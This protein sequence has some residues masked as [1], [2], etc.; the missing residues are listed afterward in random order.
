MF[1]ILTI[2]VPGGHSFIQ[3]RSSSKY[4]QAKQLFCLVPAH[5]PRHCSWQHSPSTLQLRLPHS[6]GQ[7]KK[8]CTNINIVNWL[9]LQQKCNNIFY[10]FDNGQYSNIKVH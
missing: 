1:L 9:I 10:F 8:I 2:N 3:S 5:P 7:T 4:L 6:D